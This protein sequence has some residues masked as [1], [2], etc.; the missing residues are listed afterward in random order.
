MDRDTDI[1]GLGRR[2]PATR[3]SMVLAARGPD[4]E[5]RTRAFEALVAAYWK[6]VYKYLRIKWGAGNED[7]KD[8]TQ[9]FFALAYEKGFF[10][11]YDP[12]RA[13]FR[14]YLRTCLDGF[15]AN[16]RKAEQRLK[17]GGGALTLSL[18]FEDAEG[19]LRQRDLPDSLDMEQYF[20]REWVRHL[21]GL[22][23]EAL[24]ERCKAAD[25]DTHYRL[26]ER[27][28][29]EG[30]DAAERASYAQ[31]ALEFGLPTT[32]VTNYLAWARREFRGIVLDTLHH[33]SGSDEE[34]RAEARLVLGVEPP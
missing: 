32:Q 3:L 24:R 23:V 8:L 34:F 9:G 25:K 21:F 6:P 2:F 20:H 33:V 30:P 4:P 13:R 16:Q 10:E 12:A 11:R 19:E 27:Y 1:G 7:A 28:D 26:F 15:V 17:R 22:A 31:L 29:L 5:L 14:T 18:D